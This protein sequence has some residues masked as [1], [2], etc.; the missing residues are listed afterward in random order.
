MS[1]PAWGEQ[2]AK[3]RD[4]CVAANGNPYQCQSLFASMTVEDSEPAPALE[5][6]IEQALELLTSHDSLDATVSDMTNESASTTV[7][8]DQ[9]PTSIPQQFDNTPNHQITETKQGLTPKLSQE[10]PAEQQDPANKDKQQEQE[11]PKS[12]MDALKLQIENLT[13]QNQELANKYAYDTRKANIEKIFAPIVELV[14]ADPKTGVVDEKAYNTEI[15]KL[16]KKNYDYDEIKELAQARF[17]NAKYERGEFNT[18][19][20]S[21][22]GERG[23]LTSHVDEGHTFPYT[24]MATSN[25]ECECP[26]TLGISVYKKMLQQGGFY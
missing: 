2:I 24:K 7:L 4:I 17:I 15:A 23:S 9:T 1:Q 25:N 14:F 3:V 22:K 8:V 11:K 21:K 12:E 18:P 20:T 26:D 5:F 13:K 19:P 6:D 10:E 16:V